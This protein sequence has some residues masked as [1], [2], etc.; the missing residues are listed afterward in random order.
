MF[1]S[2]AKNVAGEKTVTCSPISCSDNVTGIPLICT[3]VCHCKNLRIEE[4]RRT[5]VGFT[6]TP[7]YL[8]RR[9]DVFPGSN[10]IKQ[11]TYE[12]L[13][14]QE[15][16]GQTN[17]KFVLISDFVR[18]QQLSGLNSLLKALSLGRSSCKITF[19]KEEGGANS[20]GVMVFIP[21]DIREQ[22]L[23]RL[24]ADDLIRC[25]KVCKSWKSL[26]SH[27]Y[28]VKAQH[29]RQVNLM[30]YHMGIIPN[31]LFKYGLEHYMVG[32]SNGLACI[33]SFDGD[34]IIVANPW[35]REERMLQ[36][37]TVSPVRSCWGFGYDALTDDYKVVF[38]AVEDWYLCN[39]VL[40]WVM[41]YGNP[42]NQRLISLDLSKKN[43]IMKSNRRQV[44]KSVR[45][46]FEFPIKEDAK[47][48]H[49]DAVLVHKGGV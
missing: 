39:G 41:Y 3:Q 4:W 22:I 27:P 21:D 2:P 23:I 48:K 31:Y 17:I 1:I 9:S 35:T 33:N 26:I 20:S 45:L 7:I 13:L 24:D 6:F 10:M 25:K 34:E 16:E 29:T 40:H 14:Q 32:S 38:E 36:K 30:P 49:G 37:L 5:C 15:G 12:K 28:F 44:R 18:E 47:E 42:S 43:E 46:H 8:L 11:F 19:I